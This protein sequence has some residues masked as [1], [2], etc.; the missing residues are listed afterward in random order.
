VVEILKDLTRTIA[1]IIILIFS[2][3]KLYAQPTLSFDLKKP[4]KFEN[5]KLASEKTETT[6][7]HA[8]RRFTQNGTTKFNFHFNAYK[9]LTDVI[10]R[11][12][13]QHK[14]DYSR[15]LSFYNYDL[16]TTAKDKT[17]LDS[18]IYKA[19]AGI[20]LHDLRNSWVDNLYMLMG[21]AYYFKNVLDSAYYTFQYINYAF[22]PKEK[23]GYDKP[24]GSNA[25]ADEG[26]NIFSISTK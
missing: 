17:E 18:V 5:R 13:S 16:S 19:N 12:K 2:L 23:D 14:D 25:N 6:K 24:I 8:V 7:F 4:Q 26:G 11:G 21:E 1:L 22:S 10:A 20:L 9:K 3:P 15:L